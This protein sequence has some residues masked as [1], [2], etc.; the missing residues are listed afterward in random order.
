MSLRSNIIKSGL[1]EIPGFSGYFVS[2][3][4]DVYSTRRIGHT[5][6]DST[7]GKLRR[8]QLHKNGLYLRVNLKINRKVYNKRVHLL[9]L[10]TFVGPRPADHV[11][12]H[13]D[14]NCTNNRLDNLKWGTRQENEADKK[15]HGKAIV[16][17]QHKLAKLNEEKVY[18][19]RLLYKQGWLQRDLAQKFG[20]TRRTMGDALNRK[21]WKHVK[22][23]KCI[24]S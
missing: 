2:K 5:A 16:G 1:K 13:I 23:E 17:S 9:I 10:E 12:R 15:R 8:L 4:G 18:Q 3:Y 7:D 24:Q 6:R 22:E 11:T 14:G 21:T 20:V 19:A